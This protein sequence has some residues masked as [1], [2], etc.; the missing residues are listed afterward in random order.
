ML[1]QKDVEGARADGG[2]IESLL[3]K[4]WGLGRRYLWQCVMFEFNSA[5]WQSM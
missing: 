5:I 1:D 2:E 3:E 4:C